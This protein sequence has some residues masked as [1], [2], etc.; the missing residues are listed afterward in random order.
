MPSIVLNGAR[1]YFRLE[2]SS[3]KEPLLLVHPIGADL[4]LWD[5][6][7]PLLTGRFQVLRYDL[8]GHGGS[9]SP[10][11]EYTVSMLAKDLLALADAVGW[12]GFTVCGV[13]VGGMT[14]IQAALLAPDRVEKLIVCST[15]PAMA[16]PPGGWDQ[17][18]QGARANGM[19]PSADAMVERMFSPDFRASNDP[20]VDTLRTV[21]LRMDPQG[22]ASC[23]AVLRDTNLTDSLQNV[24]APTL[25][26]TG[27]ADRLVPLSAA[28]DF[29]KGIPNSRHVQMDG[30][31]F[32]PIEQPNAFAAA[33]QSIL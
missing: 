4:S 13:S 1:H 20:A 5:K 9:E 6:V 22:Y 21:Y 15:S 26:V 30:G 31:H 17:R 2:G 11:G 10:P 14:A 32:P 23:V 33:L 7:V 18:A 28:E 25:V 27:K 8:R 29:L 12:E 24:I 19:A 16:P 3:Q